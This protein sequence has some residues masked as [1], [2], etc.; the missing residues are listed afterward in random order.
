MD[1]REAQPPSV[2]SLPPLPVP[3]FGLRQSGHQQQQPPG[4]LGGFLEAGAP[5]SPTRAGLL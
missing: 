3:P 4:W 2:G 1:R 5:G